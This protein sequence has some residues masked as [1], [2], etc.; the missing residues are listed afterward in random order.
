M[1]GAHYPAGIISIYGD[2]YKY[3]RNPD[4][5]H[6]EDHIDNSA[7]TRGNISGTVHFKLRVYRAYA[8][9]QRGD[10]Q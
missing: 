2:R 9:T 4:I 5:K 8:D 10:T 7:V 1:N 3:Y 6:G